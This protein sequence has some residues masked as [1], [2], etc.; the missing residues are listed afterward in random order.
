MYPEKKLVIGQRP[1]TQ[2]GGAQEHSQ[3]FGTLQHLP[4]QHSMTESTKYCIVII[5]GDKKVKGLPCP[6]LLGPSSLVKIL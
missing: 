1:S 2:G 4:C 6:R 5:L 3:T